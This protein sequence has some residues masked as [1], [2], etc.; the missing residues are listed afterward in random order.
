MTFEQ[1]VDKLSEAVGPGGLRHEL[2]RQMSIAGMAAEGRA[3]V[4]ATQRLDVRSGRLRASITHEVRSEDGEPVLVLQ[5]GGKG[6]KYAGPQE[7]GATITP[8]KAENLAIPIHPSLFT[9]TGVSRYKSPRDVPNKLRFMMSR[10]GSKLLVDAKTGEPYYVL[11]KQV[12]IKGRHFLRDGLKHGVET[13][14]PLVRDAIKAAVGG[15]SGS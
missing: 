4:L 13:L 6:L 1:W 10:R 15:N 12:T 8:K 7:F 2:L 3:K 9:G 14:D 5:A 11:K